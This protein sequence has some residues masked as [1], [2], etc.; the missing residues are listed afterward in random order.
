VLEQTLHLLHPFMPFIT[1]ELWTQL[2]EDRGHHLMSAT[3][4]RLAFHDS[5]AEA[6]MDW[7]VRFISAIRAVRAEMNVPPSARLPLL[8][9][10]G[11]DDTRHRLA[12]H[13]EIIL[14]LARG[15]ALDAVADA[16]AKGAVQV[17]IEEATVF[18]PLADIIDLDQEKARLTKE[19]SRLSAEI[20]KIEKKLS[21]TAFISKAPREV[22]EEQRER[23]DEWIGSRARLSEALGRLA[24]I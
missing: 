12:T 16:P 20:D 15:A 6:E 17:V 7:L 8:V 14:A 4:P 13:R 10:G 2:G 21:N 23:L 11:G 18:L 24:A 22:V 19:F 3:W 1:E 9:K 5:E